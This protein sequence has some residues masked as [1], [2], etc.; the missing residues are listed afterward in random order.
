MKTIKLLLAIFLIFSLFSCSKS[1]D[2]SPSVSIVA[3]WKI[4]EGIVE[5]SSIVVD[6]G[7]FPISIEVS[8]NFVD[9]DDQNRLSFKEDN[10]FTSVTGSIAVELNLIVMGI[11]Q[12]ERFE[13][14]DIFGQGTWELNGSELKIHNDNGTTIIY[15]VDKLT[16]TELELSSNVSDMTMDTG[17]NPILDDLDI[18]VRIKLKKV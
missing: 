13:A 1:D 2:S 9:I 17:S 5:P 10:T 4:T 18:I 8:G 11:P 15:Q 12:T 3:D 6:M 14:D 16:E 7:G